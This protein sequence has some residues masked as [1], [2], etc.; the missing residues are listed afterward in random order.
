MANTYLP[1]FAYVGLIPLACG[2]ACR[3]RLNKATLIL[4]GDLVNF[5]NLKGK[6]LLLLIS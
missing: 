1:L 6:L 2:I 5:G 3:R 4:A